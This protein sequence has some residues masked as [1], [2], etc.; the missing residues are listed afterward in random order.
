MLPFY[1]VV[2]RTMEKQ[3]SYS[4]QDAQKDYSAHPDIVVVRLVFSF[5][6][7]AKQL[8]SSAFDAE[9]ADSWNGFSYEVSQGKPIKPAR[10]TSTNVTP[11]GSDSYTEEWA[12]DLEFAPDQFSSGAA[13]VEVTP[14][15]GKT[16][17]AEFDLDKLK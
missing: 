2:Q 17:T 7:G 12:V 13:D 3:S 5:V 6:P 1:Q 8:V 15:N 14:P 16:V 11:A 10:V 4:A 9:S